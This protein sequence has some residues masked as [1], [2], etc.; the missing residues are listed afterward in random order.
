MDQIATTT[1]A[2]P[3]ALSLQ[4]TGAHTVFGIVFVVSGVLFTIAGGWY[5][6]RS[7]A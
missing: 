5:W 1:E 2:D 7:Q 3:S 4:N 6:Q